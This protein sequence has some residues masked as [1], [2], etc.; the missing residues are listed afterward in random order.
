V[1]NPGGTLKGN[2]F[3][4][5]RAVGR[6]VPGALLVPT[7]AIRQAQEGQATAGRGE[8]SASF[9]Y[10]IRG[11]T[12]DRAPVSLGVVDEQAGVAEVVDGLEEGDQVIVGN[13]SAVG[14]GVRVQVLGGGGDRTRAAGAG[15]GGGPSAGA[16]P[17]AGPGAGTGGGAG[18]RSAGGVGNAASGGRPQ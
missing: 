4:T 17:G 3:A 8:G 16:G 1:P 10:R 13:V 12:A 5:G 9:V 6:V 2:T 14:R 7:T 18:A 15:P 11:G